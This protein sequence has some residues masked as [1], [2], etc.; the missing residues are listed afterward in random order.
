[1]GEFVTVVVLLAMVGV[2]M[3][4]IHR[5]RNQRDERINGFPY[6]R[7]RPV[8]PG[9][10]PSDSHRARGRAGPIGIGDRRD[11][12]DGGRGRFPPRRRAGTPEK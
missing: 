7:S 6:D 12:R 10:A 4:L 11:H 9:P 1:M 2:G 8:V 5:L 3:L